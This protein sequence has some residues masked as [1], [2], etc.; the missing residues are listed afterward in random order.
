MA[1]AIEYITWLF[2]NMLLFFWWKVA[3]VVAV[4]AYYVVRPDL[5]EAAWALIGLVFIDFATG[6]M[7]AKKRR[8]PI[9]SMYM[10]HTPLKLFIY[11]MLLAS[12][13][14]AALAGL[15]FLIPNAIMIGFLA[16]T[17]LISILENVGRMG[18]VIPQKLLNQ[19][20][21]YRDGK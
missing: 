13:R 4:L 1:D 11:I 15:G 16:V 5:Q 8:E 20:E 6:I 9:R 10:M 12:T 21:E 19:L 3:G 2:Q 17:E 14:L 18:F 7:A